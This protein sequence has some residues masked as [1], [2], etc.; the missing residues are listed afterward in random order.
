MKHPKEMNI[1]TARGFL[2][3]GNPTGMYNYMKDYG[4][5]YPEL[6]NGVVK[7]DSLAG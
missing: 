4:Y 7:G 3:Q 2:E 1:D 6:A 5:I